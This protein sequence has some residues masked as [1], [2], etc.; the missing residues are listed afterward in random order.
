MSGL[1]DAPGQFR[2]A[3][4]GIMAG[5][6]VI[7]LAPPAD[8]VQPLVGDLLRWLKTTAEHPLIASSV[9]HYEFEFIHPFADGNGRI[10]RLWQTLILSRWNPL[11]AHVPV[12]S[13]VHEHQQEYYAALNQSTGKADS[14]PFIEFMLK[15]VLDALTPQVNP[16]V[17]PQVARLLQVL[18]GEMSREEIQSVLGLQDR[19]SF[20][21][22][23]LSPALA[24]GLIEMTIPHKPN[25]RLQK[26]R[27]IETGRAWREGA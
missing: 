8:R 21:A 25:S 26:Y 13:L 20:R 18:V 10:G 6:E 4:V 15:M 16:Q 2:T 3:G 17:T 9:F 11:F 24:E 19:K 23:Y 5:K 27:L 14:A 12:E 22:L 1:L 7:H